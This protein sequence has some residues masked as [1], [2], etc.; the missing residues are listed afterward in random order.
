MKIGPVRKLGQQ[1]D[2]EQQQLDGKAAI[3]CRMW[4]KFTSRRWS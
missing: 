4:L 2:Q 3:A 1:S